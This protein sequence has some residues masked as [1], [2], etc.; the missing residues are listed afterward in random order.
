MTNIDEVMQRLS[1][2]AA[3]DPAFAQQ[4]AADPI[5]AA[6]AAGFPISPSALASFMGI[7]QKNKSDDEIVE[8]FQTRLAMTPGTTGTKGGEEM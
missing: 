3:A 2:R 7:D 6:R 1:D 8:E 5:G 4:L